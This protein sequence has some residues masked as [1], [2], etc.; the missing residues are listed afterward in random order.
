MNWL[1]STVFAA[2]SL[3]FFALAR[4]AIAEES[5]TWLVVYGLSSILF[6]C[7]FVIVVRLLLHIRRVDM[8]VDDEGQFICR[9]CKVVTVLK[10]GEECVVC[11]DRKSSDEIDRLQ[12]E[13]K[14][15]KK[16]RT[17]L[18]MRI[19]SLNMERDERQAE[20][21]K[22]SSFTRDELELLSQWIICIHDVNQPYLKASDYA[23]GKKIMGI[24]ERK[25][26]RDIA[27]LTAHVTS[28]E[29][30]E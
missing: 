27:E 21:D 13:L 2:F 28:I 19:V 5:F 22:V 23:L 16:E 15:V 17:K 14:N 10:Y 7:I 29:K 26:P 18:A 1:Y 9:E 4:K 30:G 25:I 20:L 11:L 3:H 6:A 12:S 8:L 24:I